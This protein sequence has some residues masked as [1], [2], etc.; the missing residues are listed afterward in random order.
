[1][2]GSKMVDCEAK[3][4]LTYAKGTCI[5]NLRQYKKSGEFSPSW[6]FRNRFRPLD[7]LT[8]SASATSADYVKCLKKLY[9]SVMSDHDASIESVRVNFRGSIGSSPS[10]VSPP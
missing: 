6:S 2:T 10:S 9:I 8:L 5:C 4:L 3:M 1:M 7:T